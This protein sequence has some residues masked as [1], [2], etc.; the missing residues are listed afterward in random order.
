MSGYWRHLCLSIA[1]VAVAPLLAAETD[2]P[3]RVG[4]IS[5]A[6]EGTHLRI[7]DA[8]AVG[9]TALNWPLTTGA[10]IETASASRTEA[11]I[12][13]TALRI[14]GGSSLEFVELSDERIWL[15]LNR[16]SVVLRIQSPEHAAE[17][18]LDTPQGRLRIHAPGRYRAD[19][20]G[21]T[22]AFSAYQGTAHIEDFGL[23][24]RAGDR[25]FLL[26]GADRNYLL[27]Q[28]E[29][30]TFSQ[31]ELA[32]EQLAVRGETRYISPEMTGHEDLE[33]HGSWQETSEYGPA[34]FPQGMPLGWAPYRQG[35][36]AWVSP[37]GWTWIDHAPWGFAPFHYGRWA[38][39]GNN[40]AWI[41]GAYMARPAYAPALIVWLGQPG[42]NASASFGSAPAVGWFPL[43]P[44]EIY[45]PH[46]RSSLRHVR[47]INVTHVTDVSRIVSVTSPQG[48][49]RH[50]HRGRHEAMTVVPGKAVMS[51][52]PVARSTTL[53]DKRALA[54]IP[55]AVHRPRSAPPYDKAMIGAV[56]TPQDSTGLPSEKTPSPPQR[57]VDHNRSVGD[58]PSRSLHR[59][60]FAATPPL[61][62]IAPAQPAAET[63]PPTARSTTPLSRSADSAP[64]NRPQG[65][66]ESS[67]PSPRRAEPKPMSS[68]AP[69]AVSFPVAQKPAAPVEAAPHRGPHSDHRL[70]DSAPLKPREAGFR[71]QPR[72]KPGP[73]ER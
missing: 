47:N 56:A 59:S 12:G 34:W 36:W 4:R 24:V 73:Q 66:Q 52:A 18:T 39:I 11:R 22:A 63:V 61:V 58:H 50:I 1:L 3:G 41:P 14:D 42:W 15:R 44:R 29:R 26:E 25:V 69:A 21:G 70:R 37:W 65:I 67:L 45:Y 71:E 64:I 2:P 30:D 51:G 32:R 5:L 43:G 68:Q 16:G 33:R 35:R 46:Y 28:A 31:W 9:V 23:T 49:D 13:S 60:Q 38:L 20:A 55:V 7:G 10:L 6:N 8:V 19:V 72:P 53:Q 62:R 54:T 40:W 48:H 27:G 17:M 57:R